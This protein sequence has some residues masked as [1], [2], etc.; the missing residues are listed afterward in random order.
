MINDY[1]NEFNISKEVIETLPRNNVK[2]RTKCIAE[3]DKLLQKQTKDRETVLEEIKLR[4][5]E[6]RNYELNPELEV[7]NQK[8]QEMYKLMPILNS[9][10]TSY[11]KSGLDRIF[12]SLDHFYKSS[13]EVA[14]ENIFASIIIFEKVGIE[15]SSDDFIYSIYTKIQSHC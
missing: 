2:N 6:Y 8:I 10:S 9:T 14:N 13:L 15:L 5:K 12:Y 1:E 11:E 7:L 4:Y 3:I